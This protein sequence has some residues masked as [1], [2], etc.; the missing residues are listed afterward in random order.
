[1]WTGLVSLKLRSCRGFFANTKNENSR[2]ER[3]VDAGEGFLKAGPSYQDT[4]H[5]FSVVMIHKSSP[6]I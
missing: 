4:E 3:L 6:G 5:T 2:G 1:M